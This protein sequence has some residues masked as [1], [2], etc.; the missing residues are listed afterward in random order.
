MEYRNQFLHNIECNSFVKAV[1]ALGTDKEKS[2]LKFDDW[3]G[4]CDNEFRYDNAFFNLYG[5]SIGIA[6]EKIRTRKQIINEKIKLVNSLLDNSIYL[7]DF[8]F[9]LVDKVF[10][11]YEPELSD[12]SDI[13]KLKAQILGTIGEEVLKLSETDAYRSL[14]TKLHNTLTADK[15]KMYLK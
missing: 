3:K 4:D 15:L 6:L 11:M 12:P 2:L 9:D 13:V 7:I 10:E 8:F 1:S 14:Q 5:K